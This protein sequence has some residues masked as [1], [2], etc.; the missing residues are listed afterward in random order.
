MTILDNH[1]A[2]L[3]VALRKILAWERKTERDAVID[4]LIAYLQTQ[5]RPPHR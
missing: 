2:E 3:N 5:K 1:I 4:E